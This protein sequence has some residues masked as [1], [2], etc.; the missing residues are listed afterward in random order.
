MQVSEPAVFLATLLK[1]PVQIEKL[2]DHVLLFIQKTGREG[3][4]PDL[5]V[6]LLLAYLETGVLASELV[7]LAFLLSDVFA[8]RLLLVLQALD[9]H[10]HESLCGDLVDQ[11]V[12]DRHARDHGVNHGVVAG[13]DLVEHEVRDMLLH[14]LLVLQAAHHVSGAGKATGRHVRLHVLEGLGRLE[15]VPDVGGTHS[16]LLKKAPEQ[17][18]V[19]PDVDRNRI[20]EGRLRAAHAHVHGLAGALPPDVLANLLDLVGLDPEGGH[21]PLVD[22]AGERDVVLTAVVSLQAQRTVETVLVLEQHE[23]VGNLHLAF[24]ILRIRHADGN[25]RRGEVD[26][27][28]VLGGLHDKMNAEIRRAEEALAARDP[29][30]VDELAEVGTHAAVFV[31]VRHQFRRLQVDD[32]EGAFLDLVAARRLQVEGTVGGE[33]LLGLRLERAEAVLVPLGENIEVEEVSATRADVAQIT[34]HASRQGRHGDGEVARK[35]GARLRPFS[36]HR[37]D[38]GWLR[39][40]LGGRLGNLRGLD[41]GD[42]VP[43]LRRSLPSPLSLGRTGR[44][45]LSRG[46]L[47]RGL[48]GLLAC[49]RLFAFRIAVLPLVQARIKADGESGLRVRAKLPAVAFKEGLCVPRQSESAD[50][51]DEHGKCPAVIRSAVDLLM[52]GPHRLLRLL[53]CR[54]SL[55]ASEKGLGRLVLRQPRIVKRMHLLRVGGCHQRQGAQ[56]CTMGRPRHKHLDKTLVL[57]KPR[58]FQRAFSQN[59]LEPLGEVVPLLSLQMSE[60]PTQHLSFCQP[61][62]LAR[63][64]H[65]HILTSISKKLRSSRNPE[66]IL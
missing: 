11:L 49:G 38:G 1:H 47:L 40:R 35:D 26:A 41:A 13:P 65:A 55:H 48:F 20:H 8:E 21:E 52:K 51:D 18:R 31:E 62:F 33:K 39:G 15:S 66:S 34:G 30:E 57:L 5:R 54:S 58:A 3:L 60:S 22:G 37:H 9:P 43:R 59:M 63:S 46:L 44:D 64:K 56:P 16:R 29:R 25:H 32:V 14:L 4:P 12:T 42:F 23:L 53:V 17:I 45:G 10:A 6:E 36:G 24:Q 61:S 28:Q 2:V 7:P 27:V 50:V 19:T